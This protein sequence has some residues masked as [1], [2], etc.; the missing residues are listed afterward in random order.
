VYERRKAVPG[1]R[2]TFTWAGEYAAVALEG[3]L[4]MKRDLILHAEGYPAGVRMSADWHALIDENLPVVVL[5]R[6]TILE[7]RAPFFMR[8][9]TLRIF[10]EGKGP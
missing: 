5:T 9:T 1:Y 8:D 7:C 4:K 3:A 6:P 10:Q 2:D